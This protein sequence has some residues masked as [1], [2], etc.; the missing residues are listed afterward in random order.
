V[1]VG[2]TS[3]V[4]NSAKELKQVYDFIEENEKRIKQRKKK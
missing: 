3:G 4:G 2:N 1:G